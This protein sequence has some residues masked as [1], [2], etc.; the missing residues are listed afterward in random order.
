MAKIIEL[1]RIVRSST[2]GQDH[3][4]L[5]A[6]LSDVARLWQQTGSLAAYQVIVSALD[7]N[8]DEVRRLAEEVLNRSSPRPGNRRANHTEIRHWENFRAE[9]RETDGKPR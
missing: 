4:L 9:R 7:S 1:I 2:I 6:T 8:D 5:L 3:S